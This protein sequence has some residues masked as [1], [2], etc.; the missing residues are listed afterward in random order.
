MAALTSCH[1]LRVQMT[2]T[3]GRV[4]S[5]AAVGAWLLLA[6]AVQA[7]GRSE[8]GVSREDAGTTAGDWIYG[9]P[10]WSVLSSPASDGT[11]IFVVM[12]EREQQKPSS[13]AEDFASPPGPQPY[14]VRRV[15]LVALDLAGRELW[16]HEICRSQPRPPSGPAVTL[17]GHVIVT[18]AGIGYR[19]EAASGIERSSVSLPAAEGNLALANDGSVAIL[20]PYRETVEDE[21]GHAFYSSALLFYLEP[22][23]TTRW[24]KVVGFTTGRDL[25][26]FTR[27][28]SLAAPLIDARGDVYALCDTCEPPADRG[29]T[30]ADPASFSRF[31][32]TTGDPTALV[33]LDAGPTTFGMSAGG[34]E[35]RLYFTANG[36]LYALAAD[37]TSSRTLPSGD[38]FL[39]ADEGPV[40]LTP[41]GDAPALRIG[42]QRIPLE[43][44]GSVTVPAGPRAIGAGAVLMSDGRWIDGNG[45]V[46]ARVD[47]LDPASAPL[48]LGDL[49]VARTKDQR[50]HGTVS[51]PT[52]GAAPWPFLAGDER[53]A[54]TVP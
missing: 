24:T 3:S 49:F 6:G 29:P 4:R 48:L 33:A 53:A 14:N 25:P 32:G 45:D 19:I 21:A 26:L 11:R 35:Q 20:A 52:W 47:D 37:G 7:C 15:V 43:A 18:C 30:N 39:V 1:T 44:E 36:W 46:A 23:L 34:T 41:P 31:D 13:I 10:T 54:R 12:G 2:R 8:H 38:T 17:D 40:F 9:T 27:L 50:L 16:L 22:N 42:D 51:G 28:S 5:V